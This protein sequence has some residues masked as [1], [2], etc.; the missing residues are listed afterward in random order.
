MASKGRTVL[1]GLAGLA[2]GL[3]GSRAGELLEAVDTFAGVLERAAEKAPAKGRRKRAPL[4]LVASTREPE[5]EALPR[6]PR[7]DV[8]DVEFTEGPPSKA[9]RPVKLKSPRR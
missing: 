4:E 5:R 7:A 2:G 3:L 9:A 8:I 1:Q 6:A